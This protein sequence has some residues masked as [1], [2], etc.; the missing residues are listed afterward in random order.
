[1]A[2]CIRLAMSRGLWSLAVRMR[3]AFL[4]ACSYW[5]RRGGG[6]VVCSWGG[7]CLLQ[8][9]LHSRVWSVVCKLW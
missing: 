8:E 5:G 2:G 1:M 4:R 3:G 9:Q 7:I 6:G